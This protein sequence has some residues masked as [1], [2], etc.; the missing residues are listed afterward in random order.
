MLKNKLISLAENLALQHGNFTLK[1]GKKSNYFIDCSKL[2]LN[3][4]GLRCVSLYIA[5][6]LRK[7]DYTAIGGPVVGVDPIVGC[8][9]SYCNI[10]GFL[11]RSENKEHGDEGRIVGTL[12]TG[13]QCVMLEDTITTGQTLLSAIKVVEEFGA[14]VVK[15][16]AVV[17]RL[18]GA[19]DLL[20]DYNY[21]SLL[22]IEDLV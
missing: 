20:S 12:K 9:V 22:T 10:R 1:S 8:L 17:D 19:K 3:P 2:V 16:I 5:Q 6:I 15:T 18:E 14:K 13:D 11:V 21:E 7:I 4:Q